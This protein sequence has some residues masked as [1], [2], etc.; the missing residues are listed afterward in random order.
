[1]LAHGVNVPTEESQ[2]CKLLIMTSRINHDQTQEF[3]VRNN[4]FG[5]KRENIIFFEQAV[6][7]TIFA[8]NGKIIM[9][10]RHK[11]AMGPNGNGALFE[12]VNANETVKTILQASEYVQIIGVDNVLN[13]ILDPVYIGFTV[14]KNLDAA[15]KSCVKRDAKEPVGV[16]VKRGGNKYD[17]I[18]YSEFSEADASAIIP[19][20]GE[21]KYNLGNILVFILKSE[22]LLDL[23]SNSDTMNQLY[24]KA[25]KK[26]SYYDPET[27][28]TIA[29]KTPNAWKFELFIH[30]FLPFCEPGK[31]G[32]LK[33]KREEEFGPVKNAEG[34]DSPQSAREL[35]YS[36]S[37]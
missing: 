18:E 14:A 8:E 15:M 27:K 1:M 17:I 20:T 23:A 33:V 6:L 37:K 3:F 4:Y 19:E 7:P 30:N 36:L 9:E 10:D 24:H 13:R 12:A 25:F 21:L 11:I 31:L 29:P 16:L 22:K 2:Q 35:I 5:A 34:V 32:V 26:I 28:T